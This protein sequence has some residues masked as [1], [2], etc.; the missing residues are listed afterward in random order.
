MDF[1]R[2]LSHIAFSLNEP[3]RAVFLELLPRPLAEAIAVPDGEQTSL[4][5]W[6]RELLAVFATIAQQEEAA[7]VEREVA[8]DIATA[9]PSQ[10]VVAL[11]ALLLSTAPSPLRAAPLLFNL[12]LSLQ[13][14]ALHRLLTLSPLSCTRGLTEVECELLEEIRRQQSGREHWGM[15]G[16]REI[17]LAARPPR[18]MQRLLQNLVEI[19]R[20]SALLFQNHLYEFVDLLQLSDRDLQIL[21]AN[22]SNETLARALLDLPED[23][24]QRFLRCVSKRRRTMIAEES[25]RYALA[26]PIEIEDTQRAVLST[27]RFLYNTRRITTYFASLDEGDGEREVEGL[28]EP[29]LEEEQS[30]G[31]EGKTEQRKKAEVISVPL[32]KKLLLAV[33]AIAALALWYIV[34]FVGDSEETAQRTGSGAAKSDTRGAKSAAVVWS[35][36]DASEKV[37]EAA[38]GYTEQAAENEQPFVADVAVQAVVDVPGMARLE[39]EA[40]SDFEP[41]DG[42]AGDAG[43]VVEL[44]VGRLRAAVVDSDFILRTPVVQIS[45]PVGAIYSTRV[46]LD[47][48]TAISVESKWVEVE[49]HIKP[50]QKWRLHQGDRGTFASDGDVDID[51]TGR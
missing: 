16:A 38:V 11:V 7:G 22:E 2:P 33:G 20:V 23:V 50:G 12:P 4:D 8:A 9:P 41:I 6:E 45:G 26:T 51:R 3:A 27:A 39:V 13:A 29:A 17:L 37:S 40:P 1:V 28:A 25:E 24:Q 32:R 43:H 36:E 14:P 34:L 46:V 44:R 18:L 48:T 35:G 42:E 5:A 19:D 31:G 15:E 21:L 49:S 47:A 10:G 30:A